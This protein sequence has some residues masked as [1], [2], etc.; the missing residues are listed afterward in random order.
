LILR[1]ILAAVHLLALGIGLGA[2]WGRA[3]ALPSSLQPDDLRRVVRADAWWGAAGAL[4]IGTGLW[5]LL[6]GLEKSSEY[7]AEPL[8]RAVRSTPVQRPD[9]RR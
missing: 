9:L 6:A 4:W 3:K 2:V 5:R 7:C 1:W 8:P